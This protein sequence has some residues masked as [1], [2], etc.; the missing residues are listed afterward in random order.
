MK[1]QL[2]LKLYRDSNRELRWNLR[3]A[4]GRKMANAGEGYKNKAGLEKALELVLGELWTWRKDIVVDDQT[5][6][7]LYAK[8]APL[9]DEGE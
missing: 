6:L 9:I 2:T 1:K 4:N 5:G 7:G 8:T 3:A